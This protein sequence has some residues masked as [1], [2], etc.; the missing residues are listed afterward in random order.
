MTSVQDPTAQNSA[1]K[2]DIH[3]TAGKLADLRSRRE[4]A[5]APSGE[6]AIDKVHAK[7]KLTA[8]ERITALLDDGSF[9]EMDA[10]AR[11]R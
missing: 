9:V 2:P 5:M 3:T 10:L 1:D 8:R 4:A 7:G 11:H 6:A